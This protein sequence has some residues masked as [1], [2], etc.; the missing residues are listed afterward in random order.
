MVSRPTVI[1]SCSPD[2]AKRNPGQCRGGP[3]ALRFAPCGLRAAF[4]LPLGERV[5]SRGSGEAG[6]GGDAVELFPL[7]RLA[8]RCARRDPPS[9]PRGEGKSG[10]AAPENNPKIPLDCINP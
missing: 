2:E 1:A 5:P 9:P 7:T 4:P 10:L 6:E 8:L 3:P